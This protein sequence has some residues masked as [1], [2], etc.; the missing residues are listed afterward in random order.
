M[1]Q[2][3]SRED[4]RFMAAAL[5]LGMRELG[6]SW[7]NPA[8]GAL[9]VRE[10][11]V[12]GRGWTQKGGRPHG[13]PLALAQAGEGARGADLYVSLEPC[14]HIG[15][16]PPCVDAIIAAGIARVVSA[17]PDPNPLVAGQGY[18]RLRE[19]GI[20]VV[21]GVLAEEARRAHA[22]HIARIL[23]KR[24]HVILKLAVSADGA[25]GF[26]G[27][28]VAITGEEVRRHVHMMRATSDAIAVGIGTVLADDPA[29]TCRL[30]G[31]ESRSPIRVVF[32]TRLQ[33]PPT[34]RLVRTARDVSVWALS[35]ESAA[36]F[37]ALTQSGV[38]IVRCAASEAHL[39][40][41]A[42]MRVLYER[43]ITRLMVEG[44]P[45][46]ASA[47]LDADLA[48]ECVIFESERVLGSGALAALPKAHEVF[49]HS[50]GFRLAS[51]TR[52]GADTAFFYERD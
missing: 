35:S 51:G 44:G 33:L 10:G 47:F 30:P 9:V 29:L 3:R 23:K 41:N 42:A 20:E 4:T 1:T 39:D 13:E 12:I 50:L 32:D 34:S 37:D 24:P 26:P 17:L 21:D 16:T 14:S 7:P 25:A 40:L 18:R 27:Q 36:N 38:D 45:A 11:Q 48:D 2:S 43:G 28:S 8:V 49:L 15:K 22:G 5:N 46:L 19:A 6:Q 52:M 31:M